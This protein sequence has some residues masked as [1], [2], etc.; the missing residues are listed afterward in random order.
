[1]IELA[2]FT[3]VMSTFADRFGMG[4]VL[5]PATATAYYEILTENLTTT[6]FLAAAK[7]LF[8]H[9]PYNAWPPPQAFIDAV[10]PKGSALLSAAEAFEALLVIDGNIYQP[11]A[12]RYARIAALGP[13]A[14]R[15]YRAVGGRR[16]FEN[17]LEADVK[18]LRQ[19]FVEAYQQA[20]TTDA[21]EEAARVA[22]DAVDE[23]ASHL[24]TE[25]AQAHT[26]PRRAEK[27]HA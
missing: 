14:M 22:L 21:A 24:I 7:L 15:A 12:E 1:M 17:V 18:Y 6:E 2:A 5:A 9:H 20:A 10:K 13:L 27:G 26:L 8:Q 23:R 25:L 11:P 4:K 16:E 3:S 19:R